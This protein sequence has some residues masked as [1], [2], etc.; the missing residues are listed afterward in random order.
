MSNRDQWRHGGRFAKKK[1][2]RKRLSAFL[3]AKELKDIVTPYMN[4]KIVTAGIT[5][6]N[7]SDAFESCNDYGIENLLC[8]NRQKAVTKDKNIFKQIRVHFL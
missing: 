3:S 6:K 7:L 5:Y 1:Q 4:K 2:L 8:K